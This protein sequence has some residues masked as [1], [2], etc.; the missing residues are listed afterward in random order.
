MAKTHPHLDMPT[1]DELIRLVEHRG[2]LIKQLYLKAHELVLAAVP[3][4]KYSVDQVDCSIGY[5]AH[6]FGYNGWGMLAVTPYKNW[7]TITFLLGA[8]LKDPRGIL[9]GNAASMRHVKISTP[10]Q[11]GEAQAAIKELITEAAKLQA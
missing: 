1:E 9:E 4:V 8:R 10:E 5:A 3:E 6:Q 2:P 11:W 7:V